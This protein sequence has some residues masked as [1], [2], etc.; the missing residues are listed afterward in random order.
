MSLVS[1][2]EMLQKA[3]EESYGVGGF[4]IFNIESIEAVLEAAEEQKSPAIL[5]FAEIMKENINIEYLSTI[6]KKMAEEASVPVALHLDH[7]KSYEYCLIAIRNGFSSVMIDASVYPLEEN[8]AITKKIVE[9]CKHLGISVEAELG[10]VGTELGYIETES[11][12]GSNDDESYKT[13]PEDVKIF[14]AE[15]DIDAL[16]V[17]IG[18]THCLYNKIA[19]IDHERLIRLNGI[20]E[21]PLV[22]HGGSGI[23]DDDSRLI[24]KEGVCKINIFTKMSQQ[25]I[26]NIKELINNG[27]YKFGVL[28]FSTTIKEGM[29]KVVTK[30]MEVFGSV[31][32]A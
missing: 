16:A 29:K 10:H 3:R 17:S 27:Q 13:D 8:I 7:G 5:M 30:K 28:D 23:S 26:A 15:T 14:I 21:V 25:A 32:K 2:K 9:Y 11:K 4:N 1:M 18:N 20:S 12:Y 31:G 24:I 22:I 6:A 19:K